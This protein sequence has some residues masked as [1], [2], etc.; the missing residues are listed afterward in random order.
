[1][2]ENKDVV[3]VLQGALHVWVGHSWVMFHWA[4][5]Y[6]HRMVCP[7]AL[8]RSLDWE[9]ACNVGTYVQLSSAGC[10]GHKSTGWAWWLAHLI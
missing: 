5:P 6:V 9:C 2:A 4:Q 8:H 7:D 3:D 10:L 1:M